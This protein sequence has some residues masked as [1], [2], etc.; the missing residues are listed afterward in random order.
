M[1]VMSTKTRYRGK[2]LAAILN[3]AF[4]VVIL[5]I[6]FCPQK[7]DYKKQGDNC[8]TILLDGHKVGVTNDIDKIY[9]LYASARAE[10]YK[11]KNSMVLTTFPYITY[12]GKE[13]NVSKVDSDKKITQ[14]IKEYLLDNETK[15][16]S[17]AYS[18]KVNETIVNLRTSDEVV[19]M[20]QDTLHKYDTKGL[21]SVS[22]VRDSSREFNVLTA[23][24][25]NGDEAGE[26]NVPLS[27]GCDDDTEFVLSDVVEG[28]ESFDSYKL[29]IKEMEFS[30]PIEIVETYLPEDK[31]IDVA[32]AKSILTEN[33]ESIRIY[34]VQSG[35]TLS[36]ISIKVGL[37]L[38]DIIALNPELENE[39]SVIRVDQELLITVPEPELAVIWTEYAKIEEAYDLPIEYVYN[40]SWYTN[41]KVTHQQ[42]SAGYHEAVLSI[43]HENDEANSSDVL[44]EEVMLPAVPKIVEVGTIVP[45]TYIKPLSG[46]R[47]SSGFGRRSAPVKGAS[48][49]HKGVDWATPIGTS[50]YASSGGTV[51]FAGW[52]S[53]YGYVVYINHPDG[54]Q[55]RYGHL[56]KIYCKVG[57][58]VNQ[59]QVI[60]ASGNTG[61]S[62]GPH[63]H[64]EIRI[65]G[66]AVNPLNYMY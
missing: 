57:D 39:N 37:P 16:Y 34:K 54:R 35:D 59:G 48:T 12:E 13:V 52:G 26:V 31:I 40:D 51:V 32:T 4:W 1:L 24:I 3:V 7:V 56:S 38:D 58:H 62:S 18:V 19:Q 20:L 55:T 10:I 14:N 9:K 11:E 49:Y 23:H 42:P 36:E 63:V 53:G 2:R 60:A 6:L 15:T 28:N 22:L 21:F 33:Q 25:A 50:I 41:Q 45:P 44:Y 43:R 8:F 29:G 46:G 27:A 64:F 17:K 66:E 47:Q 30:R 61:R 65:N 5:N